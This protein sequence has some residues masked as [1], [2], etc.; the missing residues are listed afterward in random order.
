M[1]G[2]QTGERINTS[3][4]VEGTGQDMNSRAVDSVPSAGKVPVDA[5][6]VRETPVG[7]TDAAVGPTARWLPT[8]P[9]SARMPDHRRLC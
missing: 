6:L 3:D 1:N 7:G 2:R 4:I 8:K 9:L 5:A